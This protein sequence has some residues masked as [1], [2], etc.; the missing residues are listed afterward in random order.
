MVKNCQV[1][2]SGSDVRKVGLRIGFRQFV[3]NQERL[4]VGVLC[5]FH[6][7]RIPIKN[8][9]VVQSGSEIKKVGL[10]VGFR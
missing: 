10:R 1:V 5:F 4:L 9:Q 7:L 2:Q 8:R 3:A 6:P